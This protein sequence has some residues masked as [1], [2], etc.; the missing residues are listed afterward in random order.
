MPRPLSS[1]LLIGLGGRL[2]LAAGPV[3][4]VWAAL[5]WAMA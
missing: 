2:A 4:L 3:A 1:L 5:L